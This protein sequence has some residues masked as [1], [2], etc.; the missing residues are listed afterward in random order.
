LRSAL[1]LFLLVNIVAVSAQA[2]SSLSPPKRELRGVWISTAASLDWP[3]STDPEDQQRALRTMV[4][5]LRNAHFNSVFFQTRARGDAYYRSAFEPW[6]QNLT[7]TLGQDPG[8]DPLAFLITRAHE[9]GMEVHAWCNVYKVRGPLP[10]SPSIP[11]HI[12]LAHPEWAVTQ[13]S[14]V[15]L[16]PGLPVV[17]RYLITV[18]LDLI[19]N[20]DV[21]GVMLDFIR[22]PGRDFPD[23]NTYRRFGSGIDRDVWRRANITRFVEELYDSVHARKPYLRVGSTPI[24]IYDGD[25]SGDRQG[26][27]HSYYQDSQL[28]LRKGAQDYLAPQIYWDIGASEGDP[29]FVSLARRWKEASCG[30]HI[31]TGIAAYKPQVL[32]EI[33]EQ[34]DAA[35]AAG[36]E[37]QVFFRWENIAGLDV[38]G[39]RY[40]RPANIPPMKWKDRIAPRPP[41]HLA[42][43]ELSTNVFLLEWVPPEAADDGD[44]AHCY[45]VYR[46][47]TGGISFD[48]AT[49]LVSIIPAGR[50]HFIDTVDT[51]GATTYS[52]AVTALDRAGNESLPSHIA[53]VGV[54]EAFD[55]RRRLASVTTLSVLLPRNGRA[56]ALIAYRLPEK[57]MVRLDL[58]PGHH[59]PDEAGGLL[60]R[61]RLQ[62]PGTYVVSL[63]RTE[64]PPGLYRLRLRTGDTTIEQTI[65]LRQ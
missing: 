48:D 38:F 47:P 11:L 22:Y 37:G 1:P 39:N 17:R 55:I 6:A 16:D 24:G 34:I 45:D 53:D 35:R 19:R 23:E 54:R 33:P 44:T 25:P 62:L 32:K 31:Y 27:Y 10:V 30:R 29:D 14:E 8:W 52:Y 63:G 42:A 57:M 40:E 5:E 26:A 60:L 50:N 18:V 21:D 7:G 64:L 28:W 61:Q 4:R 56:P 65:D 43:T 15:W 59:A 51:P 46:S 41:R 2:Q 13:N 49:D 58:L 20:Y 9:A 12:T 36:A 3:R